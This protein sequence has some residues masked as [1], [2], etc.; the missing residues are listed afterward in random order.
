MGVHIFFQKCD[1]E[2][3]RNSSGMTEKMVSDDSDG[4]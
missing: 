2:N 1:T 3:W 4:E